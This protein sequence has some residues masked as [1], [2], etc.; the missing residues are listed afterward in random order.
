M[1]NV[2]ETTV[3]SQ[4]LEQCKQAIIKILPLIGRSQKANDRRPLIEALV[5]LVDR[6]VKL[7]L[8]QTLAAVAMPRKQGLDREGNR[9]SIEQG[10]DFAVVRFLFKQGTLGD[11]DWQL[12]LDDG[13]RM[14]RLLDP[15]VT[16]SLIS[17]DQSS[18]PPDLRPK[19][20]QAAERT[21]FF[22]LR[23]HCLCYRCSDRFHYDDI[24]NLEKL[25]T[26]WD[27]ES[28]VAYSKLRGYDRV[29]R[30][31]PMVVFNTIFE[32]EIEPIQKRLGLGWWRRMKNRNKF[33][34][35]FWSGVL[36]GFLYD[37]KSKKAAGSKWTDP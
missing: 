4:D 16:A 34:N 30:G 24:A 2:T 20:E 6:K 33:L 17:F 12:A 15:M 37:A 36:L 32:N 19:L 11:Q 23:T 7:E 35:L 1:S 28:L 25:Y 27:L 9:A 13:D 21:V 8:T 22:G 14:A 10:A 3:D 5:E 29:N 26:T 31:S 18:A